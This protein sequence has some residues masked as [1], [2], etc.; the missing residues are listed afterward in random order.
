MFHNYFVVFLNFKFFFQLRT[1]VT[2]QKYRRSCFVCNAAADLMRYG[3]L[4]FRV[5]THSSG[6]RLK[7]KFF[8]YADCTLKTKQQQ[9]QQQSSVLKTQ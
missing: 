1:G 4:A 2:P 7:S 3:S 8:S 9:K 6:I 5:C